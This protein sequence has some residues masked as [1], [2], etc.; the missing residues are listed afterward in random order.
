MPKNALPSLTVLL[1]GHALLCR[2]RLPENA[3]QALVS[4]LMKV[5]TELVELAQEI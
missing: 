3:S 5:V 1:M 4:E 2:M